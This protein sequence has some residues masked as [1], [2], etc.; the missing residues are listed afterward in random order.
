MFQS[1]DLK[2]FFDKFREVAPLYTWRAKGLLL[3][4]DKKDVTCSCCVDLCPISAIAR[5]VI[6]KAFPSRMAGE[7]KVFSLVGLEVGGAREI[8]RA[9]DGASRGWV[10]QELFKTVGLELPSGGEGN[11]WIEYQYA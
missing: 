3:R 2:P 9:A 10:R 1:I 11:V 7:E 8:I 5:E 4:G 6:G